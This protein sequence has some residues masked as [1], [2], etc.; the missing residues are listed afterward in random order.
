VA[1]RRRRRGRFAGQHRWRSGKV[2]P[3]RGTAGR[4]QRRQS[5]RPS[6]KRS[7]LLSL[8]RFYAEISPPAR[9]RPCPGFC[10]LFFYYGGRGRKYKMSRV[11]N[12]NLLHPSPTFPLLFTLYPVYLCCHTVSLYS[13]SCVSVQLYPGYRAVRSVCMPCARYE[14]V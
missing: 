5:S 10:L 12:Y 11:R 3:A 14:S 2:S 7:P 13:Y 9:G 4:P 6:G 1:G 8:S